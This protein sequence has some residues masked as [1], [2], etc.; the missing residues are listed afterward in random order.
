[1]TTTMTHLRDEHTDQNGNPSHRWATLVGEQIIAELHVDPTTYEII[2]VWVDP[3]H[4]GQGHATRLYTTATTEMTVYHAP[5]WH[6]TPEGDRWTTSIG[7]PVLETCT[8]CDHITDEPVGTCQQCGDTCAVGSE[9][10]DWCTDN[11]N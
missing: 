8:C 2:W 7:G 6:R 5:T 9:Y 11:Q 10:C 3:D 1:M 4:Q